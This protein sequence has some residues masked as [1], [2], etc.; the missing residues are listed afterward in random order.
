[1]NRDYKGANSLQTFKSNKFRDLGKK[2][3]ETSLRANSIL[4][5]SLAE[6]YRE[7]KLGFN[8]GAGKAEMLIC[9]KRLILIKTYL[10]PTESNPRGHLEL[11][12]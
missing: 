5:L 6:L 2:L 1:M 7:A 8:V 12:S 4:F 9:R 10:N 3:I 11:C